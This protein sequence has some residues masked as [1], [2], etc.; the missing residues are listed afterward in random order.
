MPVTKPMAW[1]SGAESGMS[2]IEWIDQRY[3]KVERETK[4]GQ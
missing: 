1:T 2:I 4:V 3:T